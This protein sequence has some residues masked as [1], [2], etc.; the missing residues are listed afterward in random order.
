MLDLISIYNSVSDIQTV[1]NEE[2]KKLLLM[3]ERFQY[4]YGK[5]LGASFPS[6]MQRSK[7]IRG[8]LN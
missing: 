6:Q 1:E 3:K 8:N 2:Y 4:I 5:D 7:S